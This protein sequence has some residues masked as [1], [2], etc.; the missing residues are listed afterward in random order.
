METGHAAIGQDASDSRLRKAGRDGPHGRPLGV[1]QTPP[2]TARPAAARVRW[3]G[4][5]TAAIRGVAVAGAHLRCLHRTATTAT[6]VDLDLATGA[7]VRRVEG[8]PRFTQIWRAPSG[9]GI[10]VTRTAAVGRGP[11]HVTMLDPELRIVDT[12]TMPDATSTVASHAGGWYVG[13]RHGQLVAL[14]W[15]GRPCWSWQTPG[16]S[17]TFPDRYQRP[18]LYLVLAGPE[19]AI[20]SSF[21]HVYAVGAGGTQWH[22]ELPAESPVAWFDADQVDDDTA[23][24]T[25]GVAAGADRRTLRSAYRQLARATHPDHHPEDPMAA[26]RFAEIQDAYDR[27]CADH[28]EAAPPGP[29]LTITIAGGGPSVSGLATAEGQVAIG[30]S[31]GR[32]WRIDP[33]G[34]LLD[35]QTCGHGIVRMARRWD[36][37][38]GAVLCDG[39]LTYVR[40][41]HVG[42]PIPVEGWP[43]GLV[44]A[45]ATVGLWDREAFTLVDPDGWTNRVERMTTSP[46]QVAATPTGVVYASGRVVRS[47][48]ERRQPPAA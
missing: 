2:T 4:R 6:L 30:S 24:R 11:T 44:S 41:D 27:L 32:L 17:G 7:V 25:L 34:Q 45:E 22:A 12:W 18:C 39:S 13:C 1:R 21:G 47:Y 19:G 48:I 42:T 46:M 26:V 37:T 20:V 15:E 16:S 33:L 23:A 31:D 3:E 28:D 40:G 35:W 29:T 9:W 36:G 10:G 38:V 8:L 43:N 5:L 14:D